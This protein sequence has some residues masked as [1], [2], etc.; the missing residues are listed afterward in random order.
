MR[1][2]PQTERTEIIARAAAAPAAES[3]AGRP[4]EGTPPAASESRAEGPDLDTIARE[5]YPIIRR[6]LA[7]ERE[8]LGR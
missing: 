1:I 2:L 7:V 6:R 3:A 5:V 4:A 8:R